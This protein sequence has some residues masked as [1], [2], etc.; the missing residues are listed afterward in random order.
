MMNITKAEFEDIKAKFLNYLVTEKKVTD[1]TYRSYNAD[2]IQITNLWNLLEQEE[3]RALTLEEVLESFV[4]FLSSS[5]T[6][7]SQARKISCLNSFKK[8]LKKQSIPLSLNFKR[9]IIKPKPPISIPVHDIFSLMDNISNDDLPTKHPLRDR[10]ILE[11]LYATGMRCSEL[12]NIELNS[13]DFNSQS[14]VIRSK[15]K[16]ERIVFF[17]SKANQQIKS[18]LKYERNQVYSTNE[19]LFLNS[20]NIPLTVRSIQRICAM[21]R[22]CL[23][24]KYNITPEILRH[25]F[26]AHMLNNGA[27][28]E[29]VQKLLGHKIRASTER[30]KLNTT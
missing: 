9:P 24:N 10:A 27:D 21:F 2:M 1:N 25:S 26:A 3:K 19:R 29:T 17:G 4:K 20:R 8:F 15:R 5:V 18:Y 13:I 30:Y 23:E 12:V 6:P 11:L 28:I 14:I 22:Q 16:K 7:S